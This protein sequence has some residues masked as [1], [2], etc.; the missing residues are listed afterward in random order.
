MADVNADGFLDIFVC[1]VGKY[2]HFNGKN[3]LFINNG[4]LSFTDRTE[5]YGLQFEGFSTQSVF[6]DYDNDGDL[7]M[8]LANTP[9]IPVAVMG[10]PVY[11]IRVIHCPATS[12]IEM[13]L[14]KLVSTTSR[15][16]PQQ[17][18]FIAARSLCAISCG[19]RCK[20]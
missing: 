17:Q 7:D 10:I 4:D 1:G 6:F 5:E 11:G 15:R 2:K 16:P 8:F 18:V 13:N 12:C 14:L 19:I 9:F 20:Q 3:Q